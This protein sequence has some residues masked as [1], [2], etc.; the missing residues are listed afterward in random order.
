MKNNRPSHSILN[1]VFAIASVF[2]LFVVGAV[3]H[4]ISNQTSEQLQP[5]RETPQRLEIE[6]DRR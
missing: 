2:L 6:G 3:F 4:L 1:V 5:E